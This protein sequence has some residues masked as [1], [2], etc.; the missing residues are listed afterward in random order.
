M[1]KTTKIDPKVL[2]KCDSTKV[3]AAQRV[4]EK[5]TEI[6]IKYKEGQEWPTFSVIPCDTSNA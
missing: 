6:E 2:A 5:Q 3:V 1:W 4:E